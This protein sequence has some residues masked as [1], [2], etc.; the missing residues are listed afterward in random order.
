M[1]QENQI[2]RKQQTLILALMQHNT[3]DE[4]CKAVGLS[5]STAYRFF[6][7]PAF[8][9]EFNLTKRKVFSEAIL[10]LSKSAT[11]AAKVLLKIALDPASPATAKTSSCRAIL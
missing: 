9:K 3:L 10:F 1:K 2:T 11:I 6:N 5:R 8:M 4:A 7:D